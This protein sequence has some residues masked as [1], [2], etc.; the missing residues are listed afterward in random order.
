MFQKFVLFIVVIN[1]VV[2]QVNISPSIDVMGVENKKHLSKEEQPV[3]KSFN[4]PVFEGYPKKAVGVSVE[5]GI[6]CNM[7]EDSSLEII[8]NV[9][10]GIYV[11]NSDGSEVSGWP[12]IFDDPIEIAHAAP[13]L[14]DIDGDGEDEIVVA[15]IYGKLGSQNSNI[16]AFEKDGTVIDNFPI[17]NRGLSMRTPVLGDVDNDG[18]LDIIVNKRL[19]SVGEIW[20]YKGNGSVCSG[21]PQA[22]G[23]VPASSATCGDIDGDG[24]NE[25]VVESYRSLYVW[26]GTGKLL[27]NFP[28]RLRAG[29]TNSYSSAVL[30]D[31]DNDGKKE[32]IFGTHETVG[33]HAG[34]VYVVRSNGSLFPNWPQ[35]TA[36]WIFSAPAIADIDGDGQ[37]DIAV[38]D[39]VM[40]STPVNQVYAWGTNGKMLSGFPVGPTNAVHSQ[41]MIGDIDNDQK[42]E[43]VIDDNSTGL[44][45]AYNH[46]GSPVKGWPITA[47]TGQTFFHTPSLVDIDQNGTLDIVGAAT[48][49]TINPPITEIYIW[50]TQVPVGKTAVSMFQYNTKHNGVIPDAP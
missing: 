14:G 4:M 16:Y 45:H 17:D 49:H 27:P 7:D 12:H 13:A 8:Y 6:V 41:I 22:M 32:I 28:F 35:K 20:V 18:A 39:L 23:S 33:E 10:N 47:G 37:L 21:W 3:I 1:F 29:I 50:D 25:V 19:R 31:L 2:S 30:A 38:G 46:D 48:N 34:Y 24:K 36:M 26:K 43:L 5:G 40:S 15:T 42:M 9:G 11:W 44:Y